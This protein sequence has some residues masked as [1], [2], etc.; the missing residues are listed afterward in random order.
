[1]THWRSYGPPADLLQALDFLDQ[2]NNGEQENMGY[3]VLLAVLTF[4]CI[5]IVLL[6]RA[7]PRKKA[8][9]VN[10]ENIHLLVDNMRH[11]L[12]TLAHRHEELRTAYNVLGQA[13]VNT[14]NSTIEVGTI[15]RELIYI[16]E[17]NHHITGLQ[18]LSM[19][20]VGH[21]RDITFQPSHV[22]SVKLMGT[23]QSSSSNDGEVDV[24]SMIGDSK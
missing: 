14:L 8:R 7:A 23:G 5:Y 21:S 16:L 3:Y 4:A 10:D 15:L 12:L 9:V 20:I 11:D 24:D 18:N 13:Q 6:I 2:E 1:M 22:E 19:R 17:G